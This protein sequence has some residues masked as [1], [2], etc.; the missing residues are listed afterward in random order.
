MKLRTA[1]RS[2]TRPRPIT[3]RE[4]PTRS[5]SYDTSSSNDWWLPGKKSRGLCRKRRAQKISRFSGTCTPLA[6]MAP[7]RPFTTRRPLK[8]ILKNKERFSRL[9]SSPDTHCSPLSTPSGPNLAA[10]PH[11]TVSRG[12]TTSRDECTFGGN[13]SNF[14]RQLFSRRTFR[15]SGS[16][17]PVSGFPTAML[18]S[19]SSAVL[20]PVRTKTADTR[21]H[22]Q[23]LQATYRRMLPRWS[24]PAVTAATTLFA[25]SHTSSSTQSTMGMQNRTPS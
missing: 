14:F 19:P 9:S 1:P 11:N 16:I 22:L 2:E 24:R 25:D 17:F 15:S 21:Q 3:S 6:S 20:I 4:V 7:T 18:E 5:F 12:S 13:D 8:C 10:W 23:T